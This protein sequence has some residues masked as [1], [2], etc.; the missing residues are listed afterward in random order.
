MNGAPAARTQTIILAGGKGERL[1]PLTIDRPKPAVSFGGMFRIID[2]TLSNCLH[3]KLDRVSLLTQYRHAELHEYIRQGWSA[4]WNEKSERN[5]LLCLPP[6]GGKRYRGT[7][8][9]VFQN[10]SIIQR[11]KPDFVLILSGDHVYH[12]DY[13]DRLHHTV[14]ERGVVVVAKRT[15]ES[16]HAAIPES[17][18]HP[19]AQAGLKQFHSLSVS[20]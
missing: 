19:L 1:S 2:F 17:A 16:S 8:D 11:E 9:A 12:M 15:H 5:P 10:L 3:S 6:A 18:R 4:S 13:S 20:A 7:A 14:T